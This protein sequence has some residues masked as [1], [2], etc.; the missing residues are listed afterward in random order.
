MPNIRICEPLVAAC[1]VTNILH[2]NHLFHSEAGNDHKA[3]LNT[4]RQVSEQQSLYTLT[5]RSFATFKPVSLR[6]LF[7]K[8]KTY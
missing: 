6:M 3:F 2:R 4:T 1:S 5:S 7:L 8:Y